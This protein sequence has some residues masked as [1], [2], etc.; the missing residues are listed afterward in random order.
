MNQMPIGCFTKAQM[1]TLQ[2]DGCLVSKSEQ[3]MVGGQPIFRV[4]VPTVTRIILLPV[5][6]K[7]DQQ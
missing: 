5:E 1:E 7:M 4:S 2:R 3:P 6:W